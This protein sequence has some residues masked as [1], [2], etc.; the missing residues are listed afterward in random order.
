MPDESIPCVTDTSGYHCPSGATN[1]PAL[2]CYEAAKDV[3]GGATV[4]V[5]WCCWPGCTDIPP[6]TACHVPPAGCDWYEGWVG[7]EIAAPIVCNPG[8]SLSSYHGRYGDDYDP[9]MGCGEPV[10]Q[11]DVGHTKYCCTFCDTQQ[12]PP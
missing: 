5:D 4:A 12:P 8:A 7:T 6:T 2:N 11:D 9:F 10:A 3:D 1:D